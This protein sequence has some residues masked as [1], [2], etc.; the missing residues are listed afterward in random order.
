MYKEKEMVKKRTKC[1]NSLYK[2]KKTIKNTLQKQITCENPCNILNE[3]QKADI[4]KYGKDMKELLDIFNTRTSEGPVYVCTHCQQLWFKHSVYNVDEIYFKTE[5]EKATFHTCRT[6]FVS[7]DGKEWICK[8]C[9]NSVKGAK[10]P[11]LSIKNKMGFP[12]L[13]PEL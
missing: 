11:K 8:T 10:I 9:R 12:Q 3:K 13:P 2:D 4:R 5:N 6:K 1:Y 7:R